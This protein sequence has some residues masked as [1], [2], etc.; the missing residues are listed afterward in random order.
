MDFLG[1]GAEQANGGI[2]NGGLVFNLNDVEDVSSDFEVLPKGDYQAIVDELE[3][4]ESAAGAPMIKVVYQITEGEYA[5]RKLF[6]YWVLAGKGAEFG[7]A[8]LKKFLVRICP[9]VNMAAFNPAVFAE[10]AVAVGK[11]VTLK[12]KI[13][14]V[15]KGEYKGEK[16]NQVQEV[17]APAV[18]GGFL[19]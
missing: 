6:D 8:K 17:L 16:R 9:E 2:D 1:L 4:T 14:T 13:Q 19:G 18:G 11:D 15:K 3:F 12:V 10:E 7:L 5:D